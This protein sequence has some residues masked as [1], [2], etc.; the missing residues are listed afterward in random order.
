MICMFDSCCENL[1]IE[2]CQTLYNE[3]VKKYV[4]SSISV[5]SEKA[6]ALIYPY[7]SILLG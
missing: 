1:K 2:D 4:F 7:L 3:S 5:I 6:E